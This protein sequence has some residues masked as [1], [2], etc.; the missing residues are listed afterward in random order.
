MK[1]DGMITA[2]KKN[3]ADISFK[4]IFA[5]AWATFFNLAFT[6]YNGYV[7]FR[8]G[9]L[10]FITMCVYYAA[11]FIMRCIVLIQSRSANRRRD[12]VIMRIDGIM[13][14][15]LMIAL[16]GIISLSINFNIVRT[17][18][19]IVMIIL[20]IYT[21]FKLYVALVNFMRK[22]RLVSPLIRT[23]YNIGFADALIALVSMM[24]SIFAVLGILEKCR[25]FIVFSGV[26][27]CMIISMLAAT[28]IFHS[29]R[30]G[31]L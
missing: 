16:T 5:A 15:F 4:T 10:W 29:N 9:S 14:V 13:L 18:G 24:L 27:V 26:L 22:K 23:V 19:K 1:K 7:G 30:R 31:D 12:S 21:V 28:M 17:H 6:V 11:L 25:A 8:N 3:M 2:I 20:V